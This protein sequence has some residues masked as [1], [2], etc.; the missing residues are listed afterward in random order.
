MSC[1]AGCRRGWDPQLLWLWHRPAAT[2]P[3]GLLAWE[4]PCAPGA[5]LKKKKKKAEERWHRLHREPKPEERGREFTEKSQHNSY[6][7]HGYLWRLSPKMF[8]F[9][10]LF[11]FL[12]FRA[13]LAAYRG[14]QAR[15]WFSA[16][17]AGLHH[18]STRPEPSLWPIPQLRA[19]P[20]P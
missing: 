20:D 14:S 10:V 17:A 5:A 11:C 12:L 8:L 2:A 3:T 7:A 16:V 9:F 15:V 4:P 18:R 19:T 6:T 13:A 1:G